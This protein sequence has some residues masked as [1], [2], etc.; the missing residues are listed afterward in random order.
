MQPLGWAG[1][2]GVTFSSEANEKSKLAGERDGTVQKYLEPAYMRVLHQNNQHTRRGLMRKEN[3]TMTRDAVWFQQQKASSCSDTP[4]P[5]WKDSKGNDCLSPY[6]WVNTEIPTLK[7]SEPHS[8]HIH[9]KFKNYIPNCASKQTLQRFEQQKLGAT[10]VRVRGTKPS[11]VLG[12][13]L[14]SARVSSAHTARA[15]PANQTSSDVPAPRM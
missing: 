4:S 1:Q 5:F 10:L 13:H 11:G 12:S 7:T 2:G 14:S 3:S 6:W 8:V 15:I 9:L